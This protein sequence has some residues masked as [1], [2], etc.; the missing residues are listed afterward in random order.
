MPHALRSVVRLALC[1]T[2]DALSYRHPHFPVPNFHWRQGK[3]P[4]HSPQLYPASPMSAY[5]CEPYVCHALQCADPWGQY[6]AEPG[7]SCPGSN[8][9]RECITCKPR[10][11]KDMYKHCKPVRSFASST[12]PHLKS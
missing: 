2:L 7:R 11:W 8:R 3:G 12:A 9:Y 10:N 6:C 5:P 1:R 4:N